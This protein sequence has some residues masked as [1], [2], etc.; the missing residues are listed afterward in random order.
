MAKTSSPRQG[1][2][3]ALTVLRHEDQDEFDVLL[4]R[5]REEFAPANQHGSFLVEQMAQSRWRLSRAG[6]LETAI[7]DRMIGSEL[8]DDAKSSPSSSP[9]Q[10]V[11]SRTS[12]VT[13]PPLNA[14]TT[15]RTPNCYVP[16]ECKTKPIPPRRALR[17]APPKLQSEPNPPAPPVQNEPNSVLRC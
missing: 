16:D 7:L 10:T 2:S 9:A 3:G 12:T 4:A 13:P 15:K 1:L 8:D 17:P 11:P 6:R 5:F 14:A